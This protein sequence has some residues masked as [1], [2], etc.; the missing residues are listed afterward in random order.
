MLEFKRHP[1]V[2]LT[3]MPFF[4]VIVPLFNKERYVARC[5]NSVLA[6]TFRNFEIVL[7]D[8]GSTDDGFHV[9]EQCDDPRLRLIRQANAGVSAARNRGILE[10]SA[11]WVAFLDAD[12]A[13]DST[14]LEVVY[15]CTQQFPNAGTI[16]SRVRYCG[17]NQPPD[18]PGSECGGPFEVDY[19]EYTLT[20]RLRAMITGATVVRRSALDI[21]GPFPSGV[22]IGEDTDLWQ[23]LAWTC[24]IVH[25][26][27]MLVEIDWDAGESGWQRGTAENPAWFRTYQQ[28]RSAGM[29]P[30]SMRRSSAI[31]YQRSVYAHYVKRARS[32]AKAKSLFGLLRMT[33]YRYVRPTTL[34]KALINVVASE[35]WLATCDRLLWKLTQR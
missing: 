8:D 5:L 28:W 32:G 19:F 17:A 29:I 22:K 11:E 18:N 2:V 6:Q 15:G 14:F 26:P 7:V 4:T 31:A 10:S 35:R 13:W 33:D 16:Y 30:E 34:A 3:S 23:R 20:G 12:D 25:I 1:A 21:A 24:K 27:K 9:V